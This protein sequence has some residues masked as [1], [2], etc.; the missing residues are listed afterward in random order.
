MKVSFLSLQGQVLQTTGGETS[1]KSRAGKMDLYG[2]AGRQGCFV[3]LK[4]GC[5]EGSC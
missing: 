2:Q 4:T 3:S 5:F 1:S